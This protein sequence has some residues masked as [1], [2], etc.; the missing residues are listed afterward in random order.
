MFKAVK[1][2]TAQAGDS[3]TSDITPVTSTL[4]ETCLHT[5]RHSNELLTQLWI[6]GTLSVFGYFDAQYLFSSAVILA[7]SSISDVG[8]EDNDSFESAAQLLQT[9]A[10]SGNLSAIEFCGHLAQVRSA[11][12]TYRQAATATIGASE[13][14]NFWSHNDSAI[15][16]LTTEMALLGPPMQEFLTQEEFPFEF[17][18]QVDFL[19]DSML[20]YS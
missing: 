15:K 3:F 17:T 1:I 12:D 10:D 6:D 14:E 11:I 8:C 2:G 19:Q 16:P 9:M 18:N 20:W 5:A 7:I 13:A 4:V